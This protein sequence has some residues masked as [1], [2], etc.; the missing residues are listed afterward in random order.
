G[1]V[2][3]SL[4]VTSSQQGGGAG[5]P[6]DAMP[7]E[8]LAGRVDPEVQKGVKSHA[9]AEQTPRLAGQEPTEGAAYDTNQSPPPRFD[10]P[11]P[12]A[13][14]PGAA[15]F[16]EVQAIFRE[17]AVP[18]LHLG[19]GRGGAP[20]PPDQQAAHLA[21]I[22]AFPAER[23]KPYAVDVGPPFGPERFPLRVA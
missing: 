9:K 5:R 19:M 14:T 7:I 8:H 6:D 22:F 2:F 11:R 12:T 10:L 1:S 23:L 13:P 21:S 17:I 18:P 20:E 3:L 4:L 16:A 15:P